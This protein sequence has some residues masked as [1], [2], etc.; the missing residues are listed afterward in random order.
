MRDL[1]NQKPVYLVKN[2]PVYVANRLVAAK[3]LYNLQINKYD[4]FLQGL[5]KLKEEI[6]DLDASLIDKEFGYGSQSLINM[7]ITGQ[8]VSNVFNNDQVVAGLSEFNKLI[9]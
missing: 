9:N 7:M 8:A 6:G 4:N 5:V 1:G 3:V 2:S